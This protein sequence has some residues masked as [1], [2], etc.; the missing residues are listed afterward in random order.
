MRIFCLGIRVMAIRSE[1][2]SLVSL[3]WYLFL[4]MQTGDSRNAKGTL[5]LSLRYD[6]QVQVCGHAAAPSAHSIRG[7]FFL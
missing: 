5:Y 3:K 6:K 1:V 7:F 2:V 4:W